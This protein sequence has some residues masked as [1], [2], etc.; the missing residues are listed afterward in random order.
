MKKTRHQPDLFRRPR[1][2]APR[3]RPTTEAEADALDIRTWTD[4]ENPP[5]WRVY[6]LAQAL[7]EA[8]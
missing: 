8:K 4:G 6:R 1:V 7:A 5:T 3:V 2:S